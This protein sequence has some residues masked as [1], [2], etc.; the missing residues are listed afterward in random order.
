MQ[1]KP[2]STLVFT[3]EQRMMRDL[4]ME[5]CDKIGTSLVGFLSVHVRPSEPVGKLIERVYA[6]VERNGAK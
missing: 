1:H 2:E 3:E 6:L 4:L 5:H